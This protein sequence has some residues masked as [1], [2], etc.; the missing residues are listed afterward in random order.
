MTPPP[1]RQGR[2]HHGIGANLRSC[3]ELDNQE[4][5]TA[6]ANLPDRCWA[7]AQRSNIHYQSDGSARRG[8]CRVCSLP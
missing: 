6:E 2:S 4:P 1:P 8:L 7:S 3:T 5:L